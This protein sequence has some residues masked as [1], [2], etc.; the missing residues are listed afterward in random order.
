MEEVPVVPQ[1]AIDPMKPKGKSIFYNLWFRIIVGIFG[2]F[3]LIGGLYTVF[4]PHAKVSQA[5]IDKYNEAASIE[6]GI[7]T[8]LHVDL[9]AIDQKEKIK[10]YNGAVKIVDD[11]LSQISDVAGKIDLHK[12][13]VSELRS[14]SA[15]ISDPDVKSKATAL[16]DLMEEEDIHATKGFEYLKQLLEMLRSYYN[17]LAVGKNPPFSADSLV[18]Q[19]NTEENTITD[20]SNK[21]V[22]ARDDFFKAAGLKVNSTPAPS[23]NNPSNGQT[24]NY[25]LP[26]SQQSP[27]Q[28]TSGN[29]Q[30]PQAGSA[31]F[32]CPELQLIGIQTIKSG[33]P[34]I[35]QN[36]D[37]KPHKVRIS[38][39]TY[40]FL[41]G[42]KKTITIKGTGNY[43]PYCDDSKVGQLTVGE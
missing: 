25:S 20:L 13:K 22:S 41:V 37:S 2:T 32:G 36:T 19:L 8:V 40:S 4:S 31:I 10:D 35:L 42:E 24:G 33:I 14:L 6:A 38:L 28:S 23:I 7:F 30:Q 1:V 15:Q 3:M 21:I 26:T 16:I 11:A 29:S 17:D 39:D 9:S 34:F 43:Q 5:F 27:Q 12:Q 18:S